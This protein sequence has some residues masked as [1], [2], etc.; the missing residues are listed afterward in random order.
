MPRDN[1]TPFAAERGV[2]RASLS[3]YA[4]YSSCEKLRTR[5]VGNSQALLARRIRSRVES[6]P[7]RESPDVAGKGRWLGSEP[8][9]V[10]AVPLRIAYRRRRCR[11]HDDR[12]ISKR[13]HASIRTRRSSQQDAP[14]DFQYNQVLTKSVP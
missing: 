12:R 1:G 14:D 8:N 7:A 5:R 3:V 13:T 11:V 9:G 10:S 4:F 2:E 6:L